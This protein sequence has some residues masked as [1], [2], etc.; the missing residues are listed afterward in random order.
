MI[1]LGFDTATL[2]HGGRSARARARAPN[3]ATIHPQASTPATPRGC[4]RWRRSCSPPPGWRGSALERI[5]VGI[6]PGTFTGLRV[7]IA[8]ARG[9]AQSL[10]IPLAGV[11][12]LA[13][14]AQE[15][16]AGA[17]AGVPGAWIPERGAPCWR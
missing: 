15:A 6:G 9:L 13:A 7:G 16:L 10:S 8:T 4:W 3:G 17:D 14:L 5:A 11:S 2:G 12:S 1:V